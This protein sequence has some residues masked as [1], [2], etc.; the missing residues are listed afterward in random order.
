MNALNQNCIVHMWWLVNAS[1]T[2]CW[3]RGGM[4][5]GVV[6]TT[7]LIAW[8][9]FNPHSGHAVGPW[10]R[11][12]TIIISAWWIR[13]SRKFSGLEFEEVHKKIGSSWAGADSSNHAVV[14]A[15]KSVRIVQQLA[16]DTV[17]LQEDKYGQQQQRRRDISGQHY[18]REQRRLEFKHY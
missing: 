16:S 3:Q 7:T 17:R 8:P 9:G 18:W 13:T 4:G 1:K 2:L 14:I 15:M 5:K 10:I 6:F 11:R 12:F